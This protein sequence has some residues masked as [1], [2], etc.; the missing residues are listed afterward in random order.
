MSFEIIIGSGAEGDFA[1]LPRDIQERMIARIF[2]LKANPLPPSALQMTE[3]L[4]GLCRLRI[5]SYRVVYKV[6][7][8]A[9][10]V[11][12]V[13]LGHRRDICDAAKRRHHRT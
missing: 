9:Q 7:V 3:D 8:P 2:E 6:D 1:D 13:A 4:R 5:G 11:T 12:I 10:T